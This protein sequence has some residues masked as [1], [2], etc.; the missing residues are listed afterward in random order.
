MK[1]KNEL[2]LS[3]RHEVKWIHK[4]S[5]ESQAFH[6]IGI[7]SNDTLYISYMKD[8]LKNVLS[9]YL[10]IF[11]SVEKDSPFIVM[12]E[13]NIEKARYVMKLI[14]NCKSMKNLSRIPE[15][16]AIIGKDWVW[17]RSGHEIFQ[18]G[19]INRIYGLTANGLGVQVIENF[20]AVNLLPHLYSLLSRV[21]HNPS[22]NGIIDALMLWEEAYKKISSDDAFTAKAE[23]RIPHTALA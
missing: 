6:E 23:L 9:L 15:E 14:E 5:G 4:S 7:M 12:I 21:T 18:D 17:C 10:D 8:N 20:F 3:K 11:N 1:G 13:E 19:V 2:Y 16:L 22:V